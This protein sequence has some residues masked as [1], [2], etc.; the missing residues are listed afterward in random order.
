MASYILNEDLL[1]LSLNTVPC[2][3][4]KEACS[5]VSSGIFFSQ[6]C[7]PLS[8]VI[9]HKLLSGADCVLSE[10]VAPVCSLLIVS[11]EEKVFF[12]ST[13]RLLQHME[14]ALL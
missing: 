3:C 14:I 1:L 5:A 2:S 12:P 9:F 4:C 11:E 7:T 10:A 8:T 6:L 13:K